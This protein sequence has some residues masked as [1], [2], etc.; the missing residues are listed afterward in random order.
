MVVAL[1][2]QGE[3]VDALQSS[4][5]SSLLP[6]VPMSPERLLALRDMLARTNSP[7]RAASL[8]TSHLANLHD[9]VHPELRA[10]LIAGLSLRLGDTA[11]ARIY[12]AELERPHPTPHATTVG[13]D[14]AGSIRAQLAHRGGAHCP[15][16]A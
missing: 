10:Y 1:A 16:A 5:V 7:G 8:E 4:P 12:L 3:S 15:G 14:A 9:G 2:T 6:F 11:A 13:E